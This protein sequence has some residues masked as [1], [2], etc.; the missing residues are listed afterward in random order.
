L[1]ASAQQSNF[2]DT[3]T[4]DELSKDEYRAVIRLSDAV[5]EFLATRAAPA[6]LPI[7]LLVARYPD[8]TGAELARQQ[9]MSVATMGRHLLSLGHGSIGLVQTRAE[10]NDNRCNKHSLTDKGVALV[11]RMATPLAEAA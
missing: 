5:N 11:R 4:M 3:S 10:V 9:G 7:F 2:K 6:L 1:P 8:R